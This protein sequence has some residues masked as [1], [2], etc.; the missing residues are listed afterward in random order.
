M[1]LQQPIGPTRFGPMRIHPADSLRSP[2]VEVGLRILT[3]RS[4]DAQDQDRV[5][6]HRP[7]ERSPL[8]SEPG[9]PD[10][11]PCV[12]TRSQRSSFALQ[13]RP[14]LSCDRFPGGLT[15][16]A[17]SSRHA[18]RADARHAD[19]RRRRSVALA[20]RARAR[21][22][23]T[24]P[25]SFSSGAPI[26]ARGGS[27]SRFLLQGPGAGARSGPPTETGTSGDALAAG[28]RRPAL[29]LRSRALQGVVDL[30]ATASA[31]T[32]FVAR[33]SSVDLYATLHASSCFRDTRRLSTPARA[34]A[35]GLTAPFEA[36]CIS[37]R[38]LNEL[39]RK[40]RERAVP[41]SSTSG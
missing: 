26:Q 38:A 24:T 33:T 17:S 40:S 37:P 11:R 36:L 25:E 19:A 1:A 14:V 20:Q 15:G 12:E 35:Q 27:A 7:V 3:Q 22:L 4:T 6:H 23:V 32:D 8:R 30:A 13:S 28:R 29:R 18:A 21:R 9:G 10:V 2:Q 16:A 5:F 34:S 41:G 31:L 39:T